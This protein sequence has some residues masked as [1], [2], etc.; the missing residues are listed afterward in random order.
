MIV[1]NFKNYLYSKDAMELA[2]KIEKFLPSAIAAVSAVDIGYLSY[3]TKLKIFAQHVD[4]VDGK[5]ATG[6][7]WPEAVRAQDGTGS[8]LNHSEHRL[9]ETEIRKTLKRCNEAGLKVILC[10]NSVGE[11]R[12]F[13]KL[14]PFAIAYEAPVLV[15]SGKSITKYRRDEVTKF[16]KE[17]RGSGILVLCGAGIS[18]AEDVKT[19]YE[20]GCDGVLIAS[21]I[22]NSKK[23]E[24]ILM[25]IAKNEKQK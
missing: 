8:L 14:K 21:A 6:F 12:K 22:A 3:Y 2:K 15:G 25:E 11:T 4:F 18:N 23:P 16:V 17:M 1:I 10:A 24:K 19:A 9:S 13:K 20:L 5:M 7:L